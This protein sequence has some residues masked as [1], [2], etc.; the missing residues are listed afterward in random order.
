[1]EQNLN[2]SILINEGFALIFESPEAEITSLWQ[3]QPP[4]GHAT[5]SKVVRVF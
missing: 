4:Y 1:M 5:P 3:L 2:Y